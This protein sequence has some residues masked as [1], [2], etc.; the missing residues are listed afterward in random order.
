MKLVLINDKISVKK[1]KKELRQEFADCVS[2]M[3]IQFINEYKTV[4]RK[5]PIYVVEM[6]MKEFQLVSFYLE[7][8]HRKPIMNIEIMKENKDE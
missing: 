8:E 6:S 3:Q 2:D 5:E 1:T 4:K 7:L